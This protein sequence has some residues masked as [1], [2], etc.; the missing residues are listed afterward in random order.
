LLFSQIGIRSHY[1]A[2]FALSNDTTQ[3]SQAEN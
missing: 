1:I 3:L 2:P